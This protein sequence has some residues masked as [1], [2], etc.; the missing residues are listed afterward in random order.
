[1]I[2]WILGTFLIWNELATLKAGYAK[3]ILRRFVEL[4]SNFYGPKYQK[5]NIHNL[6]HIVDDVIN[7]GEPLSGFSAIELEN[8]FGYIKYIAKSAM[9]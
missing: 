7:L 2:F 8:S 1:M 3:A 9:K 6:I 5:I 4:M